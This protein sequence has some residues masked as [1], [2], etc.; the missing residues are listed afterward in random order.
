MSRRTR[1]RRDPH[2]I[3]TECFASHK[4]R[5]RLTLCVGPTETGS[6]N[7][8][9]VPSELW[10]GKHFTI[11]EFCPGQYCNRVLNGSHY[12]IENNAARDCGGSHGMGWGYH[13]NGKDYT[14]CIDCANFMAYEC[15]NDMKFWAT[16]VLKSGIVAVLQGRS[17]ADVFK[18]RWAP[19]YPLRNWV[20]TKMFNAAVEHKLHG[21]RIGK[22]QGRRLGLKYDELTPEFEVSPFKCRCLSDSSEHVTRSMTT[23]NRPKHGTCFY[24]RT[25]THVALLG[26]ALTRIHFVWLQKSTL[27]KQ[28][29]L[30]WQCTSES[31]ICAPNG[32]SL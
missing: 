20:F 22:E 11:A 12:T 32:L 31:L 27:T 10:D 17:N 25:H 19:L 2:V 8:E 24:T 21:F 16:Y 4:G 13:L 28:L 7:I 9:A 23:Y 3:A 5:C 26:H 6:W 30:H 14:A 29:P 1:S 18:A 15:F